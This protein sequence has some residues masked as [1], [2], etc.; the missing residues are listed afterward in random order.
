M[1]VALPPV[2]RRASRTDQALGTEPSSTTKGVRPALVII[3]A[4]M[5]AA[6]L[7]EEVI[8]LAPDRFSIRMFGAEPHGT[9][10]R[11]VLSSVLGGFADP[12]QLWI[13]ALDWYESHGVLVHAGVKAERIDR[14]RAVVIG[15]GG[16][17]EEPY[18]HLVLATGS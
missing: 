15:G 16:K 2:R 11:I 1:S 12:S 18:D 13:R 5:A 4:G 9:Y 14:E 7:V 10:N 8:A 3:G 17:V 6:K